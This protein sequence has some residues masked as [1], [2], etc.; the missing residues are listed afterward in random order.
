MAE[1]D[2]TNNT[3]DIETLVENLSG[4][5]LRKESGWTQHL[6]IT[7]FAACTLLFILS[8]LFFR[9]DGILFWLAGTAALLYRSKILDRWKVERI[10]LENAHLEKQNYGLL[11]EALNWPNKYVRKSAARLL[12]VFLP[13]LTTE[14]VKYFTTEQL[15]TLYDQLTYQKAKKQPELAIAI[16]NILPILG[17]ET[18]LPYLKRLKKLPFYLKKQE[19]LSQAAN[20]VASAFERRLVLLREID[21]NTTPVLIVNS[22]EGMV[23]GT[24]KQK[25][26]HQNLAKEEAP[27]P[28]DKM[29][30]EFEAQL[31]QLKS[32]SMRRGFLLATWLII[33]PY[34][35]IQSLLFLSS[36]KF[37][38][39][40]LF[41]FFGILSTQFHRFTMG[42]QHEQLARQLA[43][44]ENPLCIGRLMEILDW[45]DAQLREIIIVA[46]RRLLPLAKASHKIL[47][48]DRQKQ[49]L[50]SL[51]TPSNIERRA[52]TMLQILKALEQIGD[53]TAIPS[54]TRLANL[55]PTTPRVEKIRDAARDCLEYL[56]IRS[57][58]QRNSQTLLRGASAPTMD[59]DTLLRP[60]LSNTQ[61]DKEHLLRASSNS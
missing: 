21:S 30:R 15:N 38:L 53:E 44:I 9:G 46:L 25:I 37:L 56:E 57:E 43:K 23:S 42:S 59:P 35:L 58:D 55:E 48:T 19:I 52:D 4:E 47:Q 32:P 41:L 60:A 20:K 11:C 22:Q 49:N 14:D 33:V 34:F 40:I 51:L 36:A 12:T 27:L 39:G 3:M 28:E 24:V 26:L 13:R 61:T 29:L 2:S 5:T 6:G 17:T 31:K 18:A 50:Y 10:A 45:P 16:L 1:V 54:V 7:I 8:T